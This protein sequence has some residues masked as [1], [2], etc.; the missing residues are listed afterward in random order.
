M[1]LPTPPSSSLFFRCIN[2]FLST[3][4]SFPPS[5]MPILVRVYTRPSTSYRRSPFSSG[6]CIFDFRFVVQLR[7]DLSPHL[8]FASSFSVVYLQ[9]SSNLFHVCPYSLCSI[10]GFVTFRFLVLLLPFSYFLFLFS[11]V[12]AFL[13]VSRVSFSLVLFQRTF[14]A[15]F[16]TFPV[17]IQFLWIS[18]PPSA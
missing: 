17:L 3:L 11:V 14:A 16:C 13:S 12:V 8:S 15:F 18:F 9:T 4:C 6:V 5:L 10:Q 1:F 7:L 2:L